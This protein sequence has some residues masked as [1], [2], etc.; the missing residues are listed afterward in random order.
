M[1]VPSWVNPGV[2]DRCAKLATARARS[3]LKAAPDAARFVARSADLAI[4]MKPLD[5]AANPGSSPWT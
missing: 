4:A 3:Q 5:H 2:D 1:T